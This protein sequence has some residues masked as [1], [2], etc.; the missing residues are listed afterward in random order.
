MLGLKRRRNGALQAEVVSTASPPMQPQEDVAAPQTELLQRWM[1][2]AD[3]QQ[4][5]IQALVSEISSTS[6][7]VEAE[8]EALSGGFQ[9][10]V[11]SADQQ[12]ARVESLTS[13]A[14]GIEVDGEVVPI[15]RIA[16]LLESTLSDVVEKILLL[17]KDSMSMVYALDELNANVARIEP[18]IPIE[19]LLHI[20][21]EIG[22]GLHSETPALRA[23]RPNCFKSMRF[24]FHHHA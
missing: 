3:M 4:R 20:A 12:T 5:V 14:T 9:R 11:L 16:G 10:L 21:S 2:L 18:R 17:S 23:L 24:T 1:S 15:D 13:L 7:F 22:I 19:L 8:A 6:G